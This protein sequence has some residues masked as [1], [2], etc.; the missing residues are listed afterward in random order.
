[1][2]TKFTPV[3]A[4]LVI[5]FLEK[6][7]IEGLPINLETD[8]ENISSNFGSGFWMI[9]SF[10]ERDLSL[11]LHDILN[12]LHPDIKFPLEY[13]QTEIPFLDV[14]VQKRGTNI[15]TDVYYKPTDIKQYLMFNSCHPKHIKNYVSFDYM[16]STK[17]E[18][19]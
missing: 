13:S 10:S 19:S 9:V 4:T 12:T 16:Q 18:N 8:S 11:N 7:Y 6:C 15:H 2:G 17:S 14:L 5:G 3:Y 1:M